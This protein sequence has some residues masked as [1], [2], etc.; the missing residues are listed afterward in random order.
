MMVSRTAPQQCSKCHSTNIKQDEDVLDTWFSSALWPFS[1]LG[2]PDKTP[3]LDYF[4]PTSVLVTGYDIIFFWVA[5]MIFSGLEQMGREP[6][7]YV[8]IHGL[9]RDAQGR[10]MSKSLGNGIDPLDVIDKYG[11][12]ALR[13]ALT[14]GTSPGNDMRF[15]DEKLEASRNF[16]NK[17]WNAFRFVMMNFDED[18]DFSGVDENLFTTADKWILSRINTVAREVTEN[19]ERFELGIGLQKIYEF[20]WEEFCDW[21]IELVKPRLYDREAKGRLEALYVLNKVLVNAMKLLH[22]FMPFITEEVYSHLI[23]DDESIMISKWPEYS[24]NTL[25]AEEEKLMGFIMDAVRG[26][27]NIRAEMNVPASRKSKAFFV[28]TDRTIEDVLVQEQST[29]TRLASLSEIVVQKDKS[30]IAD[31]AVAVV[32]NGAEI[33]LPLEDL[34]DLQKELERLEKEK[35]N[36]EMELDRVNKKLGNEG[37]VSK[38]PPAVIEGER[39]KLKKYT[40][41][42]E[43]I[44]ERIQTL[45]N[46]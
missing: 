43:K 1:T 45:K 30:G 24:A 20:I 17:I 19:L 8:L 11:T 5:R 16:A 28:T 12:D 46:R 13:Y 41:I 33:Y 7:R 10:K 29:F 32:V 42:Y 40:E 4:Y 9:V 31:D 3:D 27:R 35:A 14:I 44:I 37:F 22:P 18:L 15:S 26:I 6:F 36:L 38:A 25:Y 21:Y 2:W 23:T 34:I 39:E